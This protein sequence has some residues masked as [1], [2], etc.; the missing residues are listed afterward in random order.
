MAD[1]VTGFTIKRA[2]KY[3]ESE[4][5]MVQK[6]LNESM[7]STFHNRANVNTNLTFELTSQLETIERNISYL[8][9]VQA[10]YND[11]FS[12]DESGKYKNYTIAELVKVLGAV[13]RIRNQY[14]TLA[15]NARAL[16]DQAVTNDK[17]FETSQMAGNQNPQYALLNLRPEITYD[18]NKAELEYRKFKKEHSFI[19]NLIST[20]NATPV[21][22]SK[23]SGRMPAKECSA[24]LV[25]GDEL[26]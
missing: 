20:M 7:T 23:I 6:A 22:I 4:K 11:G 13:E 26:E 21:K 12:N 5:N 2:I 18:A 3:W 9:S 16:K 24:L 1:S 14:N 10:R 25:T 8:Q 17:L 19:T 15:T